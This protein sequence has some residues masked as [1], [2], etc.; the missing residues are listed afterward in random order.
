MMKNPKNDYLILLFTTFLF[1]L[2]CK[3]KPAQI[4]RTVHSIIATQI[5]SV[6]HQYIAEGRVAGISIAIMQGPDTLYNN[7][8]GWVDSSKTVTAEQGSTFLMASISKLVG[9]TMVMKLVEEG[10]LDLEDKL[11]DLLP[12]FPVKDQAEQIKLRH[13]ISMTAGLKEYAQEIDSVYL[14]T[15]VNPTKEDYFDFFNRQE[16]DFPP[17]QFYRYSNS[18]FLLLP[19]IIERA[20]GASF[21]S[22]LDRIINEP[23]GL[24]LQ[25]I[26]DRLQAG[27]MTDYFELTDSQLLYRPHFPWIKGDGGMTIS[28]LQLAH[29]PLHWKNGTII[30]PA[31]FQQ[32]IAPTPLAAGFASEYGLGVKN[33]NFAGEKMFGHSGGD[34]STYSMMFHFPKVNTTIVVLTNTNNTPAN[35]RNIFS[36]VAGIFFNKNKT[37]F[38]DSEIKTKDLQEFAGTFLRPGDK[39]KQSVYLIFNPQDQHL[40]YSFNEDFNQ[41]EKMFYLGNDEFWIER[42]P[43]DRLV[44]AR[45]SQGKIVAI[46]EFYGGYMSQLRMKK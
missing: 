27:E 8:F 7:S 31:S 24:D 20:T 21:E 12:D 19:F 11:I 41:G 5:D 33:G 15:G 43:Y 18:G 29:Y 1:L 4:P 23:T 10:M 45:N 37:I 34:K 25:L 32:M 35:A 26:S 40:Y 28:A 2:S 16:L 13:L 30:S 22:H 6:A 44:Y 3:N 17:G 9:A 36:E 39:P 38:K 42:W 14:S 46:K